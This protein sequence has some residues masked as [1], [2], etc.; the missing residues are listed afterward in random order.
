MKFLAILSLAL[1][2]H[3]HAGDPRPQSDSDPTEVRLVV[4]MGQHAGFSVRFNDN[5]REGGCESFQKID[6]SHNIII[7][8]LEGNKLKVQWGPLNSSTMNFGVGF[9]LVA[10]IPEF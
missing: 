3:V 8:K 6:P 1:W 2:Q 5:G 9:R 10:G 7:T 4:P